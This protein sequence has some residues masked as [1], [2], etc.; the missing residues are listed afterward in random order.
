MLKKII[1]KNYNKFYFF[2]MNCEQLIKS[3][4][5]AEQGCD[6]FVIKSPLDELHLQPNTVNEL[7]FP[8]TG[9]TP[10]TVLKVNNHM[11]EKPWK[12]IA[13]YLYFNDRTSS[14]IIPIITGKKIMLTKED[15]ICHIQLME[16]ICDLQP[17]ESKPILHILCKFKTIQIPS[18]VLTTKN[19]ICI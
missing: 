17:I 18:L 6:C 13:K 3:W 1:P 16:P 4:L 5:P 9:K 19:I 10:H 8:F 15:T 12:V 2:R 14:L 11:E 7:I